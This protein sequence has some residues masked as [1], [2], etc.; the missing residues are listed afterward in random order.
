MIRKAAPD[1]LPAIKVCIDEAYSPY[2]NR[3]G[4]RPKPMQSNYGEQVDNGIVHVM[5]GE[6]GDVQGLIVFYRKADIM[7]LENVAVSPRHQGKGVGKR[8]IGYCESQAASEGCTAIELF[9]HRKLSENR[10][11][12]THLGYSEIDRED[13]KALDRVIFRKELS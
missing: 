7:L 2:I 6:D 5:V 4:G 9:T 12:Y 3:M 11:L 13:D 8:L 10:A 1:D